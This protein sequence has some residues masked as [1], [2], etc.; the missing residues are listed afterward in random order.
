[1]GGD[2]IAQQRHG[3]RKIAGPDAPACHRYPVGCRAA[4]S[5]PPLMGWN[6]AAE[7]ALPQARERGGGHELG[8]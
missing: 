1:M 3:A 8:A 5:A 7:R 2:G 6:I 4:Q